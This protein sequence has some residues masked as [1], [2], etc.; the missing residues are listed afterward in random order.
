MVKLDIGKVK[1]RKG[2]RAML[3][4]IIG[5]DRSG[6]QALASACEGISGIHN[7]GD[8]FNTAVNSSMHN[9]F[10]GKHYEMSALREGAQAFHFYREFFESV[11]TNWNR[12]NY[13]QNGL[14][15]TIKYATLLNSPGLAYYLD[16]AGIAFLHIVR[17]DFRS[18]LSS[19]LICRDWTP[20]G[21]D[22]D[23]KLV[24]TIAEELI[25]RRK[26]FLSLQAIRKWPLLF[27]E[28]VFESPV[29]QN[30]EVQRTLAGFFC[31]PSVASLVPTTRPTLADGKRDAII[32]AIGRA[33]PFLNED[34]DHEHSLGHMNFRTWSTE[35]RHGA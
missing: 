27:N 5:E 35:I 24:A 7:V 3:R 21:S 18:L 1:N 20:S 10:D 29:I 22:E 16:T 19:I 8:I 25:C 4:C 17:R 30:A 12:N 28:D 9:F 2:D 33:V 34:D 23:C 15:F 6:V 26:Y 14:L 31:V 11:V 32:A 13:S